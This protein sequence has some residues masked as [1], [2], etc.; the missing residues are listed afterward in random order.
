MSETLNLS[1]QLLVAEGTARRCFRHPDL[2]DCCIKVLHPEI[3]P[4][5][6]WREL[7]YYSGLQRRGADFTHLTRCRGLIDTNLGEG[8]MFDLVLD[9]DGRIS[10]SLAYY[11]A[12]N[13]SRV[14]DWVV[15]EIERLRQDLYEQWIVFHDLNP[16]NIL[17]QRIS[18]MEYRLVVI[19]GVGDDHLIPLASYSPAYAR[20]KL[21]QLWNSCYHQWYG[22]FPMVVRDLRPYPAY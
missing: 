14:N 12:Q 10:K 19:D 17:V 18:Y 22:A 13:D 5:R 1:P 6:V 11:L 4:T 21:V 7:R 16:D 2:S 3:R 15:D 8:V 20:R 9:D